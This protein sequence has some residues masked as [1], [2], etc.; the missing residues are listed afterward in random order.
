MPA[1]PACKS[2]DLVAVDLE[3]ARERVKF[4]HCRSCEHHWWTAPDGHVPLTSV[5]TRVACR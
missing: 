2:A 3:I 5:L 1:C 4:G